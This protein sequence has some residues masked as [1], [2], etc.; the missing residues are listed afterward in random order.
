[1]PDDLF[2]VSG[3][4]V[5]VSGASR[6]IG[7]A[8][9]KGFAERGASVVITGRVAET[10][11]KTAKE[12]SRP[13]GTIRAKV[14]DAADA[15]ALQR[16]AD[17]VVAEFGRIDTL[18]NCAGVNKRRKAEDYDEETYD[19]ITNINIRGAFFLSVAV[20]RH[21]IRAG[22][23]CQINIDSLN[24]HRPLDRV[25]PYAMSKAAMS[26]MTRALAMEWGPH[27]IRVNAVG[28]GLT[29]T[30][31][32]QPLWKDAKLDKWRQENT[33]LRRIGR[34]EDMVGPCLFLAS[35]AASFVT[36]QVLYVDGGTTCGLFWPIE[37]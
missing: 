31:L 8:I 12:I 19:Y 15:K 3:Q 18:V 21:M 24:S 25:A 2:S 11:E 36:G 6:G 13:G 14:C 10:L 5:L 27:G 26:N 29:L 9:A 16:L 17:E 34:P 37:V 35:A 7:R 30:E 20:G 22:R 28:P 4:I 1:M 23:G 33:P 32:T